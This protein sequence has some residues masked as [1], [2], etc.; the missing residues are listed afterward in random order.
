MDRNSRGRAALAARRQVAARRY[1]PTLQVLEDRLAPAVV[2]VPLDPNLDAFGNQFEVVQ[3]YRNDDGLGDRVTFGIFDTGASPVTFGFVDQLIFDLFGQAIPVLP[4]VEVTAEGIGGTLTGLVTEP[5]TILA[6]GLHAVDLDAF[7]DGGGIDISGATSVDN[8]QAM[9][10]TETGSPQLPSIV[11]TPILNGRLP[12]ATTDGVA[13]LIDQQGYFIDFGELFPEF[14]EF[15]GLILPLP[16]LAFVPPGTQ[17]IQEADTTA[18]VRVPVDFIGID[19]HLDPGNMLTESFN[20]VVSDVDLMNTVGGNPFEVNDQVFL[21]DTGAQLSIISTAIAE[22]LGLDVDNPE[23]TIDVG[24]AGGIVNVGG[25][26]I[27]QLTLPLD[28]DN[29]GVVDGTLVFTEAPVFVLD[30]GGFDGI[31]GMNLFNTAAKMLYDPHDPDGAGPGEAS[32]RF[33]FST[34]PR[35]EFEPDEAALD[36][37]NDFLPL[38]GGTL[39]GQSLPNFNLNVTADQP[40]VTVAEGQTASNTGTFANS[41][42]V[43]LSASLGTVTQTGPTTWSWSFAT[44]DGPAGPTNV[45]ITADDGQG[46]VRTATFTLT[47]DDVPPTIALSGDATVNEGALYTL[48]L[49]DVIDPGADTISNYSINWGDDTFT[50]GT[51][52]PVNATATHTY[53]DGAAG[54]IITVDL[55]DEDGTHVAAGTLDVTIDNVKPT[56][57]LFGDTTVNEGALYTLTLGEVTDPGADTITNYSINWGDGTPADVGSNPINAT[58]TH[59]YA[60]GAAGYIITVDLKD[61]DDDYLA[62]GSLAVTVNN[63]KPTIALS[64]DATVN[65]GALYTL[66]LGDVIDPGTDTITNYLINWGDGTFTDET[67]NPAN[68]TATHTYQG[69]GSY[70]IT[71]ELTDEDG[72]HQAAGSFDITIVKPTIEVSG[73]ATVNEGALYTL[74]L[75]EVTN[76]TGAITG[77]AINWGDGGEP[78]DVTGDPVNATATHIYANGPAGYTITVDLT[79][80]NGLHTAAGTLGVTIDDVKPSIALSG[81]PTVNEGALYTLSLGDVT[82][83]GTDTILTYSINWGDGDVTHVT[84]NPANATASHTYI[85]GP[86]GYTITVELTDEDGVH[87]DAGSLAVSIDDVPPTIALVGNVDVN[88]L[89]VYTL[90]LGNVVDPGS[91]TITGYQINWGDGATSGLNPGSPNG[92]SAQHQ[93]AVPGNPTITIDLYDQNGAQHAA[94]GSQSILVRDVAPNL[95]VIQSAPAR[96]ARGALA[97]LTLTI[98]NAGNT[99]ANGVFV[100]QKLPPRLSFVRAGST[101]GWQLIAPRTYRLAL[102]SLQP[103]QVIR[104]IFKARIAKTARPGI[105]LNMIASVGDDGASGVDANLADNWFKRVVRVR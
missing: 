22:S 16:D 11:G 72:P 18:P 9:L 68:T 102:G 14:P 43:Q 88:E 38:F 90:Q 7:L 3:I 47:I 2:E 48:S 103:G 44:T 61:E 12:G 83:P 67:G 21:F 84:G 62:A 104:V 55:T 92:I 1:R 28:D 57:V 34:L 82:D 27:D 30:L 20:P 10:G 51:G 33:T 49:G 97:R 6:D 45:T 46:G 66:S 89:A 93:Y 95:M 60:D 26:T 32:L 8:V 17:L 37:L 78:T 54:Y 73:D 24:G 65:E 40:A 63:V 85:D 64:G 56:I 86:A 101:L 29:D 15:E 96:V 71:V 50:D 35:E 75:G 87:T 19:N 39:R 79:D 81:D 100:T 58:A 13:V 36:A 5:G 31:L 42:T 23:F 77:Y 4:G 99:I 53:A 94:A 52:D 105:K 76:A 70:T 59:T 41:D 69:A 91:D 98:V 25:F 80:D 74:T